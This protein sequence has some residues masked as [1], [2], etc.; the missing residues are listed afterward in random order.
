MQAVGVFPTEKRTKLV[1]H[2]E[3]TLFTSTQVKV[4]IMDV[5]VCGTDR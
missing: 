3:P 1:E 2:P 4:P 5:G